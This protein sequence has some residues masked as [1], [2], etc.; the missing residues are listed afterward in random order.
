M[1]IKKITIYKKHENKW[2]FF[3]IIFIILSLLIILTT[4]IGNLNGKIYLDKFDFDEDVSKDIEAQSISF[5]LFGY[6]FDN[7]CTKNFIYDFDT[8]K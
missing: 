7:N 3:A 1:P 2:M 8:G 6:C 4:I 5:T